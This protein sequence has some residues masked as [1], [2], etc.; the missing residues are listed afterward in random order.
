M[1]RCEQAITIYDWMAICK[2]FFCGSNFQCKV[3]NLF[4]V[5]VLL[6]NNYIPTLEIEKKSE[7]RLKISS[8]KLFQDVL[9]SSKG[10]LKVG[11]K[12]V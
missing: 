5:Q 10:F 8:R 12:N 1:F 2:I 9:K 11:E 6:H 7:E 4:V 3:Y